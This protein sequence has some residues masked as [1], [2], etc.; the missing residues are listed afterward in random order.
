MQTSPNPF[1][2]M[3]ALCQ[4]EVAERPCLCAL[5][6]EKV[7]RLDVS[8]HNALGMAIVKR[9]EEAVEVVADR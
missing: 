2:R 4:P 8:V 9:G 7:G 3:K 5:V 6:E 1:L